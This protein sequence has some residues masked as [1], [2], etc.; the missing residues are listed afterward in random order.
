MSNDISLSNDISMGVTP[1]EKGSKT[2][3]EVASLKSVPIQIKTSSM[4]CQRNAATQAPSLY[5]DR[6]RT[7]FHG[8]PRMLTT[9]AR[10]KKI[11]I[12]K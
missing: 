6:V 11:D 7:I 4:R 8:R 3:M 2:K 10:S 5:I 1:I 9:R 12:A